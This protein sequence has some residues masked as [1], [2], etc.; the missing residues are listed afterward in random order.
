MTTTTWPTSSGNTGGVDNLMNEILA[1]L[2]DANPDQSDALQANYDSFYEYSDYQSLF[3]Y[4]TGVGQGVEASIMD[5]L[6]VS[7]PG[8]DA[9]YQPF[10]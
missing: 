9:T 1:Q 2:Q 10:G 6:Y 5:L 8:F 4:S 3:N 7:D